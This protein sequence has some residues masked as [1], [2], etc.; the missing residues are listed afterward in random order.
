[1]DVDEK[2]REQAVKERQHSE[3]LE[4][5]MRTRKQ[6]ELEQGVQH[7]EVLEQARE[8]LAKHRQQE[9]HLQETMLE[10]TEERLD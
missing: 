10:R 6:V 4:E 1:M 5:T 9:S 8:S 3:H 7:S 2:A